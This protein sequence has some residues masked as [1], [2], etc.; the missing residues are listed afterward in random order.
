MS[1][2]A[3]ALSHDSN[4]VSC[5]LIPTNGRLLLLPN[6]CV[7]EI[8]PWRRIKPLADGPVWCMG[9]MGWRGQNVPVVDFSCFGPGAQRRGPGRCL[10]VMN[11][12][13]SSSGPEFYAMAADSLPRMVPLDQ[14]DLE[15]QA[16][17]LGPADVM[18][19]KVGTELTTIPDL[20]YLERCV[21][22]L[23]GMRV[24]TD[25]R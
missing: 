13:R 8:L 25:R 12:S 2:A 16:E 22:E 24:Q 1:N 5:V 17:D 11:R 19:V 18:T 3:M 4:E 23:I 10:V 6:V 14:E 15:T 20:G 9:F 21:A 7:A